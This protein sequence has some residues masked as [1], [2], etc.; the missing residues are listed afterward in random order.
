MD[1]MAAQMTKLKM[2]A[3]VRALATLTR[4][5]RAERKILTAMSRGTL[6]PRRIFKQGKSSPKG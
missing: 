1:D 5:Q 6:G 3:R 4:E 2:Q